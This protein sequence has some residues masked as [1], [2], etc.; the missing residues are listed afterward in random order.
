MATSRP[1]TYNPGSL[2]SGTEKFGNLTVGIPTSGFESTGLQWWNGPDEDLGYV[3]AQTNVDG[4]GN[5][6]QPTPIPGGL[7][8]VG[9][10]R[11]RRRLFSEFIDLSN[12]ITGTSFTTASECKT[13]L[14]S[15]NRWTSWE[16]NLKNNFINR[17][18]INDGIF[19]AESCLDT[20]LTDLDNENLLNSASLVV[21]PNGYAEGLMYSIIP[22]EVGTNLFQRSEEFENAYWNKTRCSIVSNVATA[23]DGTQTADYVVED[24]TTGLRYVGKINEPTTIGATWTF[25]FFCKKVDRSVIGIQINENN[26][27]FPTAR[28]NFDTQTFVQIPTGMS[29]SFEVYPN[30]WYRLIFTRTPTQGTTSVFG[31]YPTDAG[32]NYNG[33]GDGVSRTLIWGAQLVYGSTVTNYLPTSDRAII[34]GTIGDLTVTRATTGTR[35][36]SDG[37]IEIVPYNIVSYSEE[38]NNSYW[39]KDTNVT[40]ISNATTAPDG[41]LTAD[42][43][44][45]SLAGN[46]QI[47]TNNAIGVISNQIYTWSAYVKKSTDRYCTLV[48]W[49]NDDPV[50]RFDLDTIS[51]VTEGGPSHTSSIIDV[52]NGWRRISI[53]RTIPSTSS[54]VWFRF[55]PNTDIANSGVYL[56][57]AQI[58]PGPQPKS[59]LKTITRLNIPRIDYLNGSC[60][61][62]LVEPQRTNLIL[63]SNNFSSGWSQEGSLITNNDVTSPEG[64][65]N[66]STLSELATNDVHRTYRTSA[67]TVVSGSVYTFSFFVKKDNVR[68]VRLSLTQNASTTIWAAAQFDLDTQTFTSGVGSGGGTFSNAYITPYGNGWYRIGI[69]GSIPSTSMIP[70]LVL[71]NGSSITSSDTRGCPVYLGNTSNNVQFYGGQLELGVSMTSYIP[72]TT[73]TVTRNADVFNK[74]TI[75]SLIGQTEGTLLVKGVQDTR[76]MILRIRN[77][78]STTNSIS[79]FNTGGNGRCEYGVTKNGVM[80]STASPTAPNN[81]F[82]KNI[83]IKYTQTTMQVYLNGVLFYNYTYP[84]PTDFTAILDRIEFGSLTENATARFDLIAIWKTAITDTQA[85]NLTT[86]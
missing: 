1:F 23:P 11:T 67:I 31:I 25:S 81:Q 35:V 40:V 69:A 33:V 46:Y 4:L 56:W 38:F 42:E 14:E 53:T 16:N 6:L 10:F 74:A 48:A 80:V 17:V 57:G 83:I 68:Y 61:A 70:M 49:S 86:L 58:V 47:R 7:G 36:N 27:I 21:T 22:N 8:N 72:T 9:F 66:A 19:E 39:F 78:A 29:Y 85:I 15:N 13:Y 45:S 20:N 55:Y 26:A 73:A 64:L 60:P 59:Y 62:I 44:V 65:T 51:I 52:G 41:T 79:I 18:L 50:T 28:F 2:I 54:L 77:N 63:Q 32:G 84:T 24:N 75:N 30:G 76:G 71:S 3:I 82:N 37:L 43:I 5:P 12:T 34:N